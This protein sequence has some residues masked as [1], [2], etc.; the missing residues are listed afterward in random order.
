MLFRDDT[1][2]TFH[3]DRM[4]GE[5]LQPEKLGA[6]GTRREQTGEHLD[7]RGFS[8]TIRSEKAKELPCGHSKVN[9]IDRRSDCRI[10]A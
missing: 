2:L 5:G 3:L 7:G 6:P 9:A 1:N 10:A 8:S 4:C